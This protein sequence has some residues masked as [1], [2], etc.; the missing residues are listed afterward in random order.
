MKRCATCACSEEETR[1]WMSCH[2]FPPTVPVLVKWDGPQVCE[3]VLGQVFTAYPLVDL[4]DWCDEWRP[5]DG[6]E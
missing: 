3:E 6:D 1:G 2:R 4:D 5:K